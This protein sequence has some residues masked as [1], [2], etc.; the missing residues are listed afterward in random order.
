MANTELE[1]H[2]PRGEKGLPPKEFCR[3]SGG[4]IFLHL[5]GMVGVN[6]NYKIS[7]VG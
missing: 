2:T 6:I 3:Q 1:K 7:F 4:L 5:T